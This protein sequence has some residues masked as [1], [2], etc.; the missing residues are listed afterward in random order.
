MKI[1]GDIEI[2][3]DPPMQAKRVELMLINKK[4]SYQRMNFILSVD[5]LVNMK[6]SDKLDYLYLVRETKL[7]RMM[8]YRSIRNYLKDPGE[9]CRGTRN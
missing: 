1:F 3:A 2:Q 7:W 4:K 5:H 6:G 9:N 8:L